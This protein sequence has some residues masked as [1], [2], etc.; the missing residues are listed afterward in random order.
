MRFLH[1]SDWHLGRRLRGQSRIPEQEAALQE[2]MQIAKDS[3]IDCLLMAG[4]I[5]DSIVPGPDEQH[6]AFEFFR[7]LAKA[8][9]PAVIVGGNHDHPGRMNAFGRV[10][11]LVDLHIRADTVLPDQG[12]IVQI[13]S[14]DGAEIAEI[15]CL[16]WV[17]ERKAREWS[18]L[19]AG[20]EKPYLDYADEVAKRIEQ[21][22]SGFSARNIN[23]VVA[24][25]MIHEAV[26]E[27]GGGER[28]IHIGEVYAISRERL[29]AKLTQYFALG[30]VHKPQEILGRQAC[31]SGSLLQ[32]DFGEAG[33]Q[34]RVN[35]VDVA[36]GRPAQVESVPLTS[37]KQLRNVGSHKEGVTLE[38]IKEMAPEIRED[39]LK[40]FL[41][42][43]APVPGLA[44]QVRELLPNAVDIVVQ[45]PET[46]SDGEPERT[47]TQTPAEL[48][49]DYYRQAHGSEPKEELMTLF[50]RLYEEV[51]SEA[52]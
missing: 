15:A 52:P 41:K 9:I 49:T 14:K 38:Q 37:I 27:Q 29:P 25:V 32:L 30:H 42:I 19:A 46:E 40:V 22:C 12:G 26:V 51:T 5:F 4:D 17:S 31:Y 2:M 50:N 11:E 3:R 21:L 35:I 16:P 43:D 13:A 24:H 20:V 34:K 10:L 36:P 1:T 6:L 45:R 47:G 44:D 28:E 18:S 7:E 39:Y 8:R 33:Q 23:V 48:F